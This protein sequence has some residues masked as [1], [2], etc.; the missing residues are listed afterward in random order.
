MD[1]TPWTVPSKVPQVVVGLPWSG[2][3]QVPACWS[4]PPPPST[5][6]GPSAQGCE[7]LESPSPTLTTC[8]STDDI[9][10]TYN[11]ESN[12][13]LRLSTQRSLDHPP[14]RTPRFLTQLP[15]RKLPTRALQI[16]K[17]PLS[18]LNYRR[19]SPN[20]SAAPTTV[21]AQTRPQQKPHDPIPKTRRREK[22]LKKTATLTMVTGPA[23]QEQ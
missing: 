7:Q 19:T 11:E 10:S 12:P 3:T 20:A 4:Y 21:K 15:S 18:A 5:E 8:G 17:C 1:L 14:S 16:Q 22:A 9:P 13:S 6:A 23:Y 2:I